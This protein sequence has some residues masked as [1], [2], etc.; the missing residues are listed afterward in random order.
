MDKI[1]DLP[2]TYFMFKIFVVFLLSSSVFASGKRTTM[3]ESLNFVL[4]SPNYVEL[5]SEMG[6]R[7][8]LRYATTN[9]FTGNNL[10]G[11]FNRAFLH[12]DAAPKLIKAIEFLKKSHPGYK[13]LIFDALRP[14][15]AQYILWNHVKGTEQEQYVANPEGGSVHNY[16]FAID[17]SVCDEKGKE[18]DMGT[19]Y[20]TFS[21]LSQPQLEDK[22]LQ[23]GRLT[24][25]QLN[26]RAI[27][28]NAMES[29]GFKQIPNEWWHFD[30]LAKKEVKTKYAIVE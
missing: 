19:A 24:Q 27:L 25:R 14:R 12:K 21:A 13:L 5:T 29:S 28:K 2:E 6:I 22:H 15:S 1:Y 4:T 10:Y 17:L 18:L 23:E 7:L 9:N 8:D 30:A 11:N 3:K 26:N 20:D 16:G